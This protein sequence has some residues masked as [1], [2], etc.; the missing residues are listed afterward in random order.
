MH[1]QAQNLTVVK[2]EALFHTFKKKKVH[3][4][5]QVINLLIW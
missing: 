3:W 1:S 4:Y 2:L 5:L